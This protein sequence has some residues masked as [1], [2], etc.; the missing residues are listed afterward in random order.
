MVKRFGA[1]RMEAISAV[2]FG[3]LVKLAGC[4]VF[5]SLMYKL[6]DAFDTTRRVL[7]IGGREYHLT[8]GDFQ[9]IM[10]VPEGGDNIVLQGHFNAISDLRNKFCTQLSDRVVIRVGNLEGQLNSTQDAGDDFIRRFVLFATATV[11]ATTTNSDIKQTYL[12]PIL[13][14]EEIPSK[15]WAS[16]FFKSMVNGI[17]KFKNT[18]RTRTCITGCALFLQVTVY[19]LELNFLVRFFIK[20][21]KT[22]CI[23]IIF[24]P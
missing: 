8:A 3:G 5:K 11:L 10:G 12:F 16:I 6:I 22:F 19:I 2:G 18:K 17:K 4:S 14:V 23:I 13:D 21:F 7:N 20:I 1:N 24:Y 9:N 15:N